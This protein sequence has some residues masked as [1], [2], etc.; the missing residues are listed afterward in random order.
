LKTI[1]IKIAELR[2]TFIALSLTCTGRCGL[3]DLFAWAHDEY[4]ARGVADNLLSDAPK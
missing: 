3:L 4:G 1:S 2:S